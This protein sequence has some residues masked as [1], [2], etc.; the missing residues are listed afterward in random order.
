MRIKTIAEH[1]AAGP[2]KIEY[3]RLIE[4]FGLVPNVTKVFSIWPDIFELH[5][6]M[7]EKIMVQKS[8][9]P[10]PV[11]QIIAV[12]VANAVSCDYCRCW[13]SRFLAHMG[14]DVKIIDALLGDFRQ[15]PVDEKTL[16]LLEYVDRTVR[17][18]NAVTD[19]DIAKLREQGFSDEE[20]LEA[21]VIVG[22]FSFLTCIIEALGVEV[23]PFQAREAEGS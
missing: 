6:D 2:I 8:L 22:Y 4:N 19:N 10:K 13:H 12:L 23:E 9:L 21:T 14:V 18:A 15:A 11:K 17:D 16:T 20:I 7:Y 5:N 3:D 1:E